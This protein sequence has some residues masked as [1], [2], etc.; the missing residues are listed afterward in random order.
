MVQ[1]TTTLRLR[2][3]VFGLSPRFQRNSLLSP[4]PHHSQCLLTKQ[5][6]SRHLWDILDMSIWNSQSLLD[7][8]LV[9]GMQNFLS[10]SLNP[11]LGPEQMSLY[12]PTECWACVYMP[13]NGQVKHNALGRLWTGLE[14]STH[15]Q[16]NPHNAPVGGR[17]G[18]FT[19]YRHRGGATSPW[20]SCSRTRALKILKILIWTLFFQV[21]CGYICHGRRMKHILF[22]GLLAW[23]IVLKYLDKQDVALHLY[24]C[25]RPCKC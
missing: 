23:F 25:P 11:S 19:D 21:V 1:G 22:N 5:G 24:S 2:Q 7:P 3:K 4:P 14:W 20:K 9:T 6:D 15:R 13:S 16:R 10:N 17:S 8:P 18:R 12:P